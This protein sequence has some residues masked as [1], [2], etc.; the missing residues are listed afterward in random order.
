M[1]IFSIEVD[2]P[3]KLSATFSKLYCHTLDFSNSS[4]PPLKAL[5]TYTSSPLSFCVQGLPLLPHQNLSSDLL[6]SQYHTPSLYSLHSFFSLDS[7]VCN[8]GYTFAKNL[9][10]F[11]LLISSLPLAKPQLWIQ[12]NCFILP[13]S[14]QIQMENSQEGRR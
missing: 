9:L 14:E 3:S 13:T 6:S 2:N 10:S 1:D 11:V 7:M 4:T 5:T 8:F 12:L